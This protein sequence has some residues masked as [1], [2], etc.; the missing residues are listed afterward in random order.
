MRRLI[1]AVPLVFLLITIG[2]VSV[3]SIAPPVPTARGDTAMLSE[4]RRIFLVQCTACHSAEPVSK[5]SR[6]RWQEIV[7]EMTDDAN[8]T[9]QQERSLRS[10]LA[11]V[12]H[13]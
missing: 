11:A 1:R 4:G 12:A 13:P 2:C 3:E 9:T 10:Y 6:T 8:L 5:H 7:S